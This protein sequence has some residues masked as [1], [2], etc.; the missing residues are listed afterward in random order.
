[1]YYKTQ[2]K[3]SALVGSLV[4]DVVARIRSDSSRRD[5]RGKQGKDPLSVA[6]LSIKY[7]IG[8]AET[9]A[10]ASPEPS[11]RECAK[12][13]RE[14]ALPPQRMQEVDEVSEQVNPQRTPSKSSS[15]DAMW[16][17]DPYSKDKEEFDVLE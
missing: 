16:R 17:E 15:P 13:N 10:L 4:L 14:T 2:I 5:G 8:L 11:A 6:L 1:M 12:T 3:Y 9:R 7:M